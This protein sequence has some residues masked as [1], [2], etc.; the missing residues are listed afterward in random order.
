MVAAL[1]KCQALTWESVG[2]RESKK[3][4]KGLDAKVK[5]SLFF[6]QGYRFKFCMGWL[7][8]GPGWYLGFVRNSWA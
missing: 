4:E 1:K 8:P 3:F 7:M 6:W 5:L 2:E